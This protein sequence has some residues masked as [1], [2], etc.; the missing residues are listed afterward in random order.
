MITISLLLIVSSKLAFVSSITDINLPFKIFK[1]H[2]NF[3]TKI[4]ASFYIADRIP[5]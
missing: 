2:Y 1:K 5:Q 3:F 4:L